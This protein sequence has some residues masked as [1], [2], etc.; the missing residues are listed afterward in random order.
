MG[1]T[2][3]LVEEPTILAEFEDLADI[4]LVDKARGLPAHGPQDL[5]IKFDNGKQPHWGPIY[6]HSEKELAVLYGNTL[7]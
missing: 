2:A 5:A 7:R 4:F 3:S 6:N 1:L